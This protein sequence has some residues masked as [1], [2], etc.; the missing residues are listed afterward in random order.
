VS[1]AV[2]P[3]VAIRGPRTRLARREALAGYLFISPWLVGFVAFFI[4]PTLASFGLSF[5]RFAIVDA[6][7][8]IGLENY[9]YAL[10]SDLHFFRGMGV[11]TAGGLNVEW[12]L[13]MAASVMMMLPC[14]VVFFLAQRY[15]V[16]GIV[17]SGLKE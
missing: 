12:H 11:S 15:F 4:G 7:V 10:A 9:G 1:D 8:W 16:Q 14:I 6:P 5:T 13:M 2:T 3:G 17:V